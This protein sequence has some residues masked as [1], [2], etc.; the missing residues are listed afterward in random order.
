MNFDAYDPESFYDEYFAALGELRPELAPILQ[1][2]Q[3]LPAQDM[4]QVKGKLEAVLEKLGATFSFEGEERVLPFDPIPRV[5]TAEEWQTLAAGL[6]QRVAAL[7]MFCADAYSDQRILTE[8]VIP[9]DVVESAQRFRPECMGMKPPKG[10]WCHISGID[11][12]RN[13]DGNWCVLE[14]NL[15]V[16]SGIAYVL[17]NRMAMEQVLPKLIEEFAPMP[18][19][20]YAHHLKSVMDSVVSSSDSTMALLTPG[21]H[22]SAYFEHQ[23]LAE[24]MGIALVSPEEVMMSDGYLCYRSDD[25]PRR[26]D[27]VYRRGAE[28]LFAKLDLGENYPDSAATLIELCQAGKLVLANAIGA[29]VGDDKVIYAY[30]PDMIRF[31]LG[32][33]PLLPNVPTYLCWR[34]RDREYVLEHLEELVVKAASAEGGDDMLVGVNSTA[35]ERQ[36]FAQ[37]IRERPRGYMAQPTVYLSQIPTVVEGGI[38]GRHTDLRP[39]VLH[40]GDEIYVHP[41]G[42][43]RVALEKG[44]LVVNS[45]QGGGAKDTWVLP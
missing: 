22:D 3:A 45:S 18:V 15:R 5:I 9:R 33:E 6:K 35:E 20:D 2:F 42:L 4:S 14:D 39:Y 23:L 32:E 19:S 21:I 17:K 12:V 8:G 27:V 31:Y 24:Q 25:G 37:K 41:G 26:L 30:V 36:V 43:T 11:L 28:D 1:W 29:G 13:S 7:N 34:D 44:K 40:K 10:I 38:E 16:P